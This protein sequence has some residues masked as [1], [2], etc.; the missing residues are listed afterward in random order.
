M[1]RLHEHLYLETSR[2]LKPPLGLTP[3]YL[4]DETRL[5]EIDGAMLRYAIAQKEIP[6][7]WHD[8]RTEIVMRL[9]EFYNR[10]IGQVTSVEETPRGLVVKA[11]LNDEAWRFVSPSE[12][13]G[14]G[15]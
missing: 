10:P 7:E 15:T 9:N 3:R 11:D 4:W 13:G 6:Q 2:S 12:E 1:S 8:E 14:R 5:K